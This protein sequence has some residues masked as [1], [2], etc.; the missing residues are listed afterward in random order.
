MQN[1][2][3]T[4]AKEDKIKDLQ[5][6]KIINKLGTQVLESFR[7]PKA[8]VWVRVISEVNTGMKLP[9][10]EVLVNNF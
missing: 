9:S 1:K 4:S 8:F 5:T 7:F 2:R 3:C 6:Q 10:W